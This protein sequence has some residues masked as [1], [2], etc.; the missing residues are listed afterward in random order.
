MGS[1]D[2]GILTVM[3]AIPE[4]QLDYSNSTECSEINSIIVGV[5]FRYT[6]VNNIRCF[7]VYILLMP[8]IICKVNPCRHG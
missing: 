8:D 5:K 4:T 1:D 3:K 2:G 6:N 7:D